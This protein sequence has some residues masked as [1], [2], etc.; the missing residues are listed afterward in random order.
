MSRVMF[1]GCKNFVPCISVAMY[2]MLHSA[3]L[4]VFFKMNQSLAKRAEVIV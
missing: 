4:N 3:C 2:C 1:I